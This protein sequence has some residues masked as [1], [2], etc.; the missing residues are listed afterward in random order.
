MPTFL[1]GHV[2]RRPRRAVLVVPASKPRMVA[3][4]LASPADAVVLDL[5]DAVSIDRKAFARSHAAEVLGSARPQG[6]VLS[7]RM[8]GTGTPWFGD[9]LA[10]PVGAGPM[11]TSVVVSKAESA[12]DIQCIV[13]ALCG[14]GCRRI[15][16]PPSRTTC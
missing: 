7:V 1:D 11:V 10:M 5:E 6:P 16:G 9:D 4:A 12:R 15:A 14:G 2:D 13:D 8:N 3:K